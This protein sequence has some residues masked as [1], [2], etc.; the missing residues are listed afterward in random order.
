MSFQFL[1]KMGS[2]MG[3]RMGSGRGVNCSHPI[4]PGFQH[5]TPNFVISRNFGTNF[6]PLKVTPFGVR[7]AKSWRATK[8][9]I[10]RA[11]VKVGYL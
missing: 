7:Q 5:F 11:A 6:K 4:F 1:L 2:R 3:S 8:Q 10:R 9:S